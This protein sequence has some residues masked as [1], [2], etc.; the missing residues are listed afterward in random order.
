ME[1]YKI[2]WFVDN[3]IQ[4][5][6]DNYRINNNVKE[7]IYETS[8]DSEIDTDYDEEELFYMNN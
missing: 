5:V 8:S 1:Y 3:Y 4:Y 7:E 2:E 6:F